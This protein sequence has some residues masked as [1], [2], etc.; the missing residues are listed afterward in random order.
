MSHVYPIPPKELNIGPDVLS[1]VMK[2]IYG[3]SESCIHWFE[4][5]A[6]HN[7]EKLVMKVTEVDSCLLYRTDKQGKLDRITCLQV[8][9]TITSGSKKFCEGEGEA[10][11]SF[12]ST[13][14]NF[15]NDG[16]AIKFNGHFICRR[17]NEILID[18]KTYI[19]RMSDTPIV[20]YKSSFMSHRGHTVYISTCTRSDVTCIINQLTQTKPTE[21]CRSDYKNL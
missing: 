20:Q 8:D 11:K 21:A 18:P 10:S 1:K 12:M 16:S 15:I 9:Y 17:G 7:V 3:L 13:G 5:Y 2:P 14:L 19:D 6:Q 4:S